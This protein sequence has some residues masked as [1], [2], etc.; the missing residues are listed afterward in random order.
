MALHRRHDAA[1]DSGRGGMARKA[2]YSFHYDNDIH[3]ASLV[4]NIGVIEGNQ[5]VS[6]N[7]WETLK[8]QGDPAVKA[9]IAKEMAGKSCLIVLVG[10]ATAGRKWIDYEIEKAWNGGKGVVGIR[11]HGLKNLSGYVANKGANPFV[12]FTLEGGK[13]LSAVAKLYDPPGSDSKQV[14]KW[15]ADNIQAAV[16]EAIAIRVDA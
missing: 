6:S 3:R 12:G 11:I 14:Y 16:E 1:Y 15:I 8:N 10:S 7:Q 13:Q 5:S 9:W 4:R 2:F